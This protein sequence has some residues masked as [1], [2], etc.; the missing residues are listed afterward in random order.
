[1]KTKESQLGQVSLPFIR[2]IA[3]NRAQTKHS[4]HNRML[5]NSQIGRGRACLVSSGSRPAI[6]YSGLVNRCQEVWSESRDRRAP[7]GSLPN[8]RAFFQSIDLVGSGLFPV[9]PSTARNRGKHKRISQIQG[10]I[11]GCD[12]VQ[13]LSRSPHLA[14]LSESICA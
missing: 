6:G 1:M 3:V 5:A 12:A 14:I 8:R 10:A 13:E 4:A 7:F 2:S 11:R 9:S